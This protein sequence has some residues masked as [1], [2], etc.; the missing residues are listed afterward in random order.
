MERLPL[1]RFLVAG[2]LFMVAEGKDGMTIF[3]LEENG[4]TVSDCL[5]GYSYESDKNA[6]SDLFLV[7]LGIHE[8]N[9]PNQGRA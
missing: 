5:A 8:A 6:V 9:D 2:D 1:G 4:E 3:R 7:R